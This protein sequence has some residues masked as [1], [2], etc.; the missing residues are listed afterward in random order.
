MYKRIKYVVWCVHGI[1]CSQLNTFSEE[2]LM[3][4][5]LSATQQP[6]NARSTVHGGFVA[7]DWTLEKKAAA[8]QHVI[9]RPRWKQTRH[10]RK[11]YFF[12]APARIEQEIGV[13]SQFDDKRFNENDGAKWSWSGQTVQQLTVYVPKHAQSEAGRQA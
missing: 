8:E 7:L 6:E 2:L 13:H 9:V 4:D 5:R 10:H 11:P 3:P 1:L 12:I